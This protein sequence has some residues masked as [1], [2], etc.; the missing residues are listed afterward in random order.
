MKIRAQLW[1]GWKYKKAKS[2]EQNNSSWGA[3]PQY[4]AEKNVSIIGYYQY[5]GYSNQE[6]LTW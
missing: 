3:F 4:R 2:I 6:V 5:A 1:S